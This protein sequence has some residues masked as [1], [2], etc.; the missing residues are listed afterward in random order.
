MAALVALPVLTLAACKNDKPV[1]GG[2]IVAH[3]GDQVITTPELDAELRLANVPSE[4]AKDPAVLRQVLSEMATRKYLEQQALNAKLDR[5]PG[6]L[7]EL[8]RARSQV[9]ASAYAA[10]TASAKP[11]TQAEVDKFIANNPLKFE[12]RQTMATDQITLP[13][14]ANTASVADA[15][16]NATSLEEIDQNLTAAGISHGRASGA[17]SSADIS[18]DFYNLIQDKKDSTVFFVRSGNNGVY[19]KVKAIEPTPLK[20]DAA[21]AVARQYLKADRFKAEMG[22]ASVSANMEAKFEGE[23][24]QIMKEAPSGGSEPK[25]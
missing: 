19:F 11:I 23:Y 5:E 7:L 12:Q 2:Q 14:S 8:L 16:K 15:N 25:N 3:I 4:K 9:L 10:R 18:Q 1:A 21:Q 13:L 22:L 24:A 17:I 20:G 6:I